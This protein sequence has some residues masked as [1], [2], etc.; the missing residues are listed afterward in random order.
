MHGV[1]LTVDVEVE[2]GDQE[3]LVERRVRPVVHHGPGR[4]AAYRS[5][6]NG[7]VTISP[8]ARTSHSMLPSW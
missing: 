7:V 2:P 1:L 8:V 6:A 3:V 4:A 5:A